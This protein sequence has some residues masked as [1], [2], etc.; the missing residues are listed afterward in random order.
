MAE[1]IQRIQKTAIVLVA[2]THCLARE[3]RH[4]WPASLKSITLDRNLDQ[5]ETTFVN[6]RNVAARLLPFVT[7]LVTKFQDSTIVQTGLLDTPVRRTSALSQHNLWRL[8]NRVATL[9]LASVEVELNLI[10]SH[11]RSGL[12]FHLSHECQN[13]TSAFSKLKCWFA[14]LKQYS[15]ND[16]GMDLDRGMNKMVFQI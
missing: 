5:L 16:L 1:Q 11:L 15:T 6:S 9:E 14:L 2:E 8:N 10:L 7:R 3:P 12:I 4:R 13:L